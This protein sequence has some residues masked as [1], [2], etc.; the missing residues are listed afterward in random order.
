MTKENFRQEMTYKLSQRMSNYLS[1]K[2]KRVNF[3]VEETICAKAL[4]HNMQ[5]LAILG[6]HE[7]FRKKLP[8]SMTH[9]CP[10]SLA[11]LAEPGMR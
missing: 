1:D 5:N 3:K 6:Q 11:Q 10:S 8:A 4:R 2:R 9:H 7:Q